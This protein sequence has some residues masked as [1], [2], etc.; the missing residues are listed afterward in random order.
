MKDVIF[1]QYDI[2]GIVGSE[3]VIEEVYPLTQAILYYFKQRNPQLKTVAV[4]ADGRIHSPAIK[5]EMLRAIQD[6]G[7]TVADI[8]TCPTPVMYF[9]LY[10]FP[11]DAGL[12]ITA[13]HN[14]KEYNGIKIC[15]GKDSVAGAS[16]QEILQLYKNKK[17]ILSDVK[18]S[19][20]V[21]PAIETYI[22]WVKNHFQDL[23][24]YS[25]KV[26]IDCGNAAA[27]AV[28]PQLAQMMRW[29][30]VQLLYPDVDGNYP[31]HEA[32]PTVEKNMADAKKIMQ[33]QNLDIA[34]GLDGDCDRMAAMTKSGELVQGDKLLAVFS[35]PLAKKYPGMAV[36]FD[37]KC[38]SALADLLKSW[39]AKPCMSPSGHSII[40]QEM[41]KNKA[42][43]AGELSC[44][45]NFADRYFGYD[46]G[47]YAILRLFEIL[48]ESNKSLD[49][50]LT[51]FPK[52]FSIPEVRIVCS[53]QQKWPIVDYVKQHF[54]SRKDAELLLIDGIRVTFPFGWAIVRASNTQPVICVRFEADSANNLQRIKDDFMIPLSKYFTRESLKQ[55]F[56]G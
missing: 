43:L 25:I 7:F 31:H 3:L 26:V 27:G 51:I 9:T 15:L 47:I 13:S 50:L 18:G 55:Y 48:K 20:T 39:G 53:E 1:R 14:G 21:I 4:G 24:G 30:N 16:I 32:D 2:R 11:V 54:Q 41:K 38:S 56:D 35:Q 5:K 8:G 6:A 23:I 46:D 45:F 49:E 17:G 10:N 44:H 37:I 29:P 19:V 34:I 36:V 40:K 28:L 33:Q 42:I 52:R 22:N 12:M